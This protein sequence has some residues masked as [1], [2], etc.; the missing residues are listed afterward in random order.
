[1]PKAPKKLG[2]KD[3]TNPIRIAALIRAGPLRRAKANE[4][5]IS[6]FIELGIS[7]RSQ[8]RAAQK[9]DSLLTLLG[10]NPA[11]VISYL[12][13]KLVDK[14]GH[15]AAFTQ[16][17]KKK[18]SILLGRFMR[19]WIPNLVYG[20]PSD[21]EC[22]PLA[23]DDDSSSSSEQSEIDASSARYGPFEEAGDCD[24]QA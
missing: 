16:N 7:R 8:Y 21:T 9:L 13:S 6:E 2:Y 18:A 19:G 12:E 4:E 14:L 5:E 10:R 11:S 15:K 3:E 20:E 1:M 24:E 17:E 23:S 22:D